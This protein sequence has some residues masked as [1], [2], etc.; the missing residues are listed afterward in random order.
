MMKGTCAP[1]ATM[2]DTSEEESLASC[3][4]GKEETGCRVAPDGAP[5][6]QVVWRDAAVFA[7]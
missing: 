4:P 1:P 5:I 3:F 2:T 6:S 7:L